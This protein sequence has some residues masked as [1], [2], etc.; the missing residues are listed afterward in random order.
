MVYVAKLVARQQLSQESGSIQQF[1]KTWNAWLIR[2]GNGENMLNLVEIEHICFGLICCK[3]SHTKNSFGGEMKKKRFDS[4]EV[5]PNRFWLKRIR[6]YF[7]EIV[8]N[9]K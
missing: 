9:N 3:V 2:V 5:Q 7:A 4:S 1:K 8:I 6:L